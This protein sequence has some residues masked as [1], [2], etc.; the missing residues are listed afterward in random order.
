MAMRWIK[1]KEIMRFA[2]SHDKTNIRKKIR[3]KNFYNEKKHWE[4][5]QVKDLNI[6]NNI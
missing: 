4:T 2:G 3:L 5:C 1:F 6:K